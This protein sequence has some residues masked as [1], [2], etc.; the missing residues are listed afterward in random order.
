MQWNF[1]GNLGFP[2]WH[3]E[4]LSIAYYHLGKEI[5]FHFGGMDHI[6]VHHK[7]EHIQSQILFKKTWIKRWL[8]SKFLLIGKRKMGKSKS[9]FVILNKIVNYHYK[10]ICFRYLCLDSHYRS[11]MIFTWSKLKRAKN[12]YGTLYL[13][14]INLG[15]V[16]GDI[17]PG[18]VYKFKYYKWL[19]LMISSD[20]NSPKFIELIWKI[21]RDRNISPS[22]KIILIKAC[23]SLLT[24]ELLNY[25]NPHIQKK[26]FSLIRKRIK[27]RKQKMWKLADLARKK[28]EKHNIFLKDSQYTTKWY[29]I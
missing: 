27:F 14:T 12:T 4:C 18:D 19:V 20:L 7:N 29:Y 15:K 11:H 23:N 25:K 16:Y 1:L 21:S 10:P 26:H 13:I 6:T 9:N 28:L 8:H 3:T 5:S 2:G 24:L 17:H 22:H